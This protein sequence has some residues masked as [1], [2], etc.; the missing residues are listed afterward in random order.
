M[1]VI[2][3]LVTGCG[4]KAADKERARMELEDKARREGEAGNKAITD[5]NH[6]L[7]GKK[8]TPPVTDGPKPQPAPPAKP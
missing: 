7:F 1:V 4:E 3:L 6:R 8:T 2:T 5:L